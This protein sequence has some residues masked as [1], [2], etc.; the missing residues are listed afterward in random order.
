MEDGKDAYI[1]FLKGDEEAFEEIV[2]L[3]REPLILYIN[4]YTQNIY[5]AEDLTEDTFFKLLVKKPL[6]ISKGSFKAW[7]YTIARNITLDHLRHQ[8]LHKEVELNEQIGYEQTY[9]DD[10]K[11]WVVEAMKKINPDYSNVLYLKF[12][13]DF[14]NEEIARI[15]HKNKRQV[16]T[17][18]YRAKAA[19]QKELEATR[20]EN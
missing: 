17:L 16:E 5:E 7:I 12:Y 13:E 8:S 4:G 1:R 19:I 15:I 3:Y 18:L 6:F 9:Y 11:M 2:Y 14:S 20:D 10:K